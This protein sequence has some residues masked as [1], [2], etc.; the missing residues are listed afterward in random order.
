MNTKYGVIGD[1]ADYTSNL[2]WQ[3]SRFGAIVLELK[4]SLR[5]TILSFSDYCSKYSLFTTKAHTESENMAVSSRV[6]TAFLRKYRMKTAKV[7]PFSK[8]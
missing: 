7:F 2:K 3:L 8:E 5:R 1:M 6:V 4:I